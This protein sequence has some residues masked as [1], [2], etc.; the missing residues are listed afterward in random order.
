MIELV[1]F[2]ALAAL[3]L[4]MLYSVLGRRVGR[5]PQDGPSRAPAGLRLRRVEAQ[6]QRPAAEVTAEIQHPGL[7][8]IR[9]GDPAFELGKFMEGARGAYEQI[10]RAFARGDRETLRSLTNPDVFEAFEPAVAAREA[11]GREESVEFLHP[12]RADLEEAD[13]SGKLARLKVRFLSELRRHVKAAKVD[14]P[15]D[16]SVVERRTAEF[17]TFERPVDAK[18]SGWTLARVDAAEA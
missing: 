15:V 2:A 11:E 5:Q 9:A 18:G 1:I 12:P 17:W 10:V 4:Y 14:G 3:V 6:P 16:E 8:A 7:A 13:V